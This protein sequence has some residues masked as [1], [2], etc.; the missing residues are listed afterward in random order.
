MSKNCASGNHIW[1][2]DYENVVKSE[3]YCIICYHYFAADDTEDNATDES[4]IWK[5]G[6]LLN[7]PIVDSRAPATGL[8]KGLIKRRA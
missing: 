3:H 1:D 6:T 4:I 2:L 5:T 7:K 8:N